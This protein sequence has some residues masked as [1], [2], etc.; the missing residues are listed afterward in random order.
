M[1]LISRSLT[2]GDAVFLATSGAPLI[3]DTNALLASGV[4]TSESVATSNATT[5]STSDILMTGMTLTPASG[6][7]MA[8]FNGS[9]G[10]STGNQNVIASLYVGGTQQTE[11]V[12]TVNPGNATGLTTSWTPGTLHIGVTDIVTVNG[13]QAI[14]IRWR[15]SSGTGTVMQRLLQIV[16]L[17]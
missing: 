9:I 7:Y 2:I 11:T 15:T 3:V 4:L 8:V 13:S 10:F 17:S 12:R 1:G 6:T 16:R 14:E 5:T